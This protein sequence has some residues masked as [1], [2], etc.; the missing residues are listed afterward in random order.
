MKFSLYLLCLALGIFFLILPRD[1][2][3]QQTEGKEMAVQILY[4]NE[5]RVIPS[6]QPEHAHAAVWSVVPF[7]LLL[8]MIATG[9]LFYESFWH[10]NYP[11]ISLLLAL[12]VLLYYLFVLHNLHQPFHALAEYIQFIAL[13]ASL[14]MASG[15]ILIIVDRKSSPKANVLMLLT[16]AVIS[17]LIGTTGASMLLIRPF[18]RMNKDHI[19]AYHVVFFILMVSNIGGSLTPIGDPPLFLGFLKGV[20]FFWTLE[21]NWPAWTL[22]L[23]LL[24]IVFYILDKKLGTSG[25]GTLLEEKVYSQKITLIGRKNFLWLLIIILSVFLDPNVMAWVPAI[26]YEGQ[27]FSFLR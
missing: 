6:A 15:G 17:N 16:G 23:S 18:I 24:G 13:L 12:V 3:A 5:V 14:F 7:L 2:V 26:H 21:H 20:P 27:K 11:K 9:P 8:L 4:S 22:A 1:I 19:Q 10:R 25:N